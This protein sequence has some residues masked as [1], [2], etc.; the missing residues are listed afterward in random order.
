MVLPKSNS[1]GFVIPGNGPDSLTLHKLLR[2]AKALGL[3]AY[4]MVLQC[5]IKL[6]KRDPSK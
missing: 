2:F 5:R 1:N 4:A 6:T 3:S